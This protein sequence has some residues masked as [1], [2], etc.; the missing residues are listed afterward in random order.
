MDGQQLR[1]ADVD[2]HLKR[3]TG[4]KSIVGCQR[5][6]RLARIAGF[7]LEQQCL[8]V[9]T[10]GGHAVGRAQHAPE[11]G[12]AF[13]ILRHAGQTD[14]G[15][16]VGVGGGN[17][18]IR[19]RR[20]V[21]GPEPIVSEQDL[22]I[23]HAD[24]AITVNVG[25]ANLTCQQR[26]VQALAVA[27][28]HAAIAI[29]VTGD[30][31]CHTSIAGAGQADQL[32]A[33]L[34]DAQQNGAYAIH[35]GRAQHAGAADLYHR[36]WIGDLGLQGDD[37]HPRA[38]RCFDSGGKLAFAYRESDAG[39][40]AR[41]QTSGPAVGAGRAQPVGGRAKI[42]ADRIAINQA[43]SIVTIG[44]AG[45]GTV[46][47]ARQYQTTGSVVLVGDGGFQRAGAGGAAHARDAPLRIAQEIN[48]LASC[49]R[50]VGSRH[51]DAC[52]ADQPAHTVGECNAGQFAGA[53]ERIAGTVRTGQREAVR[54]P[55]QAGIDAT[56]HV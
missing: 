52:I 40:L 51:R 39:G 56:L 32:E 29:E 43:G 53:I 38:S 28:V 17:C 18:R 3:C 31:D 25:G 42:G 14:A 22:P 10:Q 8:A 19:L 46:D 4:R 35:R 34:G 47:A 15:S 9:D 30:A 2:P 11:D 24:L 21:V 37:R 33:G 7:R 1:A 13:Q 50:S 44:R 20:R 48:P 27:A 41:H 49:G 36:L 23:G 26:L 16:Q 12:V 6:Q 45:A 55:W 5:D 54:R